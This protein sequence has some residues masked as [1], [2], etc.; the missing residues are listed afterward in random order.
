MTFLLEN[1]QLMIVSLLNLDRMH[2][3]LRTKYGLDSL[4]KRTKGSEIFKAMIY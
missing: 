4:A 1:Y 2:F 3:W